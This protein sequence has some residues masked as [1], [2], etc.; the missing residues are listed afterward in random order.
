MVREQAP[1]WDAGNQGEDAQLPVRIPISTNLT[2]L[3]R[4]AALLGSWKAMWRQLHDILLQSR[5]GSAT[6]STNK[7]SCD[8]L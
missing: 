4:P 8:R 3:E 7:E 5:T 2:R 6:S 1:F